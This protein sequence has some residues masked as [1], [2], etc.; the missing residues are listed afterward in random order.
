MSC[1]V[2]PLLTYYTDKINIY[3]ND[4]FIRIPDWVSC[5]APPMLI[6]APAILSSQPCAPPT[7]DF[8]PQSVAPIQSYRTFSQQPNGYATSSGSYASCTS[9]R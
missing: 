5:P 6:M 3:N 8:L 2:K 7:I 1:S 4:N 9:C